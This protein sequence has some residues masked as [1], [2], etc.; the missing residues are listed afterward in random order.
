VLKEPGKH[1]IQL[2]YSKLKITACRG[3]GA[4][5]QHRN[6]CDS[7]IQIKYEDIAVRC[8]SERSQ[9][10]NKATAM[11]ILRAKLLQRQED[12]AANDIN[13]TR[14][15]Q[16]GTGMRGDKIRTI[17]AQH[18][19]VVD[20]RTRKKISLDKYMRGQIDLLYNEDDC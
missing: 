14:Q 13:Q 17:R 15:R 2:D 9:H 5:G 6:T 16:V 12:Q 3:S 1:D 4:G 19:V 18:N 20:H 10:Q 11:A 8:E 7:A